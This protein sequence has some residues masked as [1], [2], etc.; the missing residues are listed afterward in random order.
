MKTLVD[1][2]ESQ[3]KALTQIGEK[4]KLS[5]AAVIREAIETYLGTQPKAKKDD[6]FGLWGDRKIDGLEYQRKLRSEW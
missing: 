5:R 1:L 6:A 2:P 3:L 4:R